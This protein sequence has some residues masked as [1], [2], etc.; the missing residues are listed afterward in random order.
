[1]NP[2]HPDAFWQELARRHWRRVKWR[3]S[4][5]EPSSERCLA[6]GT[7]IHRA[8]TYY[9]RPAYTDGSEW[10]CQHAYEEMV[11]RTGGAS[12]SRRYSRRRETG[13]DAADSDAG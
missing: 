4:S 10:L 8:G 9:L 7:P 3:R 12:P 11:R 13:E 5:G 1:M 2:D 6:Y